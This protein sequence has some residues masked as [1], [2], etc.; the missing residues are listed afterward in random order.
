MA[1]K[2]TGVAKAAVAG[3][4]FGTAVGMVSVPRARTKKRN[5]RGGMAETAGNTL[6]AVGVAMENVADIIQR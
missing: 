3:A 6:R 5:H 2:I 1:N 4:L